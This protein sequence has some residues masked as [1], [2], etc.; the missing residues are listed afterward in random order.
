MSLPSGDRKAAVPFIMLTVLLDM[1]SIGVVAPVLPDLIA[2]FWHSPAEVSMGF[3][4]IQTVFALTQFF[5]APVLGALSD[6]FGRR[7]VVLLGL[8]GMGLT[9]FLSAFA[10][11]F[12]MLLIARAIGGVMC[13]NFAV[14]SAYVSD[15]STPEDR[16]RGFGLLSAMYALGFILGPLLG[17]FLGTIDLQLPFLVSGGLSVLN[18]LYG[19]WILPES[20][21]QERR[22]A[23]A[24]RAPWS[25]LTTLK[26]F[27]GVQPLLWIMGLTMLAQFTLQSCWLLFNQHRFHWSAHENGIS[28]FVVGVVAVAVQGG[29]MKLM[30]ARMTA[31]KVALAG[32]W[33]FTVTF[34]AWGLA[35][36][37]WVLFL[38]LVLN[39]FGYALVPVVESLISQAVSSQQQGETMGAVTSINSIAAVTGAAISGPLLA[40]V[41]HLPP[42]DWRSGAPY[43][44]C[45]LVQAMA[46]AVG[47]RHL[48]GVKHP[49]A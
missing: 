44:F 43:F 33:S 37:P 38:F 30:Q 17:G 3:G 32:L 10:T 46:L 48:K 28:L 23:F 41:A 45:A 34:V 1:M 15:I 13:A 22:R 42:Q 16:M 12:W 18:G 47:L 35:T 9:F 27:S 7:P 11:N 24:W 2:K 26:Q 25:S 5:S 14:A 20:L 21:P 4:L 31:E 39:L 8:L 40:A 49:P 36:S 6:R 29:L 19:W